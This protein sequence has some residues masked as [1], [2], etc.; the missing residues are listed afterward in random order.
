[1][2]HLLP[3]PL[4]FSLILLSGC[5]KVGF[6]GHGDNQG[7]GGSVGVPFFTGQN[8]PAPTQAP[9]RSPMQAAARDFTPHTGG[10]PYAD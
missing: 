9:E 6:S 8:A 7:G 1:M 5:G 3:L 2:R 10:Y 4:L